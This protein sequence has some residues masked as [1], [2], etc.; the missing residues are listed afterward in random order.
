VAPD[1]IVVPACTRLT[2][3]ISPP[4][5]DDHRRTLIAL[6]FLQQLRFHWPCEHQL[7]PW[8]CYL[9]LIS[10]CPDLTSSRAQRCAN[11][12]IVPIRFAAGDPRKLGSKN[13]MQSRPLSCLT[14]LAHV[15]LP[16]VSLLALHNGPYYVASRSA[17]QCIANTMTR[18]RQ[19]HISTWMARRSVNINAAGTE[20]PP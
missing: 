12:G 9:S 8:P 1:T 7:A 4:L 15:R 16:K 18:I 14:V 2:C 17:R 20:F 3:S 6:S 11:I 13:R 10:K 19:S 5:A